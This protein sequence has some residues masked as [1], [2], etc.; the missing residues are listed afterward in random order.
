M[1][2][3]IRNTET[4]LAGDITT[5]KSSEIG[6]TAIDNLCNERKNRRVVEL[7]IITDILALPKLNQSQNDN[8]Q[9]EKNPTRFGRLKLLKPHLGTAKTPG[10]WVLVGKMR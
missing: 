9:K 5:E 3:R 8:T 1:N 2:S 6:E 7:V 4:R 10:F